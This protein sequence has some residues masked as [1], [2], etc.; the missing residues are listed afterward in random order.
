MVKEID[1]LREV[2]PRSR[3]IS[4]THVTSTWGSVLSRLMRLATPSPSPTGRARFGRKKIVYNNETR[5]EAVNSAVMASPP[6]RGIGRRKTSVVQSAV[7]SGAELQRG[8]NGEIGRE[9][10]NAPRG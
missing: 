7:V 9:A 4:F 2:R 8:E 3:R 5:G 1:P 10:T 6:Q